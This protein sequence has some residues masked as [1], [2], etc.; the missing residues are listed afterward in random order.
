MRRKLHSEARHY[1]DPLT[2]RTVRQVTSHASVHHHPFFLAPAYDNRM[3]WL[4][5]VSHRSGRAEV[6]AEDRADG[7]LVQLTNQPELH[8]WSIHPSHD[9]TYLYY[10]AG[11]AAYRVEL[12]NH[13]VETVAEFEDAGLRARGMVA[14]GMGTT[15]LSRCDRYW[16]LKVARADSMDLVVIDTATRSARTVVQRDT[17]AHVQFCPDDS[18]LLFYAGSFKERMWT[19]RIDGSEHRSHYQRQEGEW[20]THESWIPGTMEL[21]F[22]DWPNRVRALHV[23]TGRIRDLVRTNA[24]HAAADRSGARMVADTNH[25]DHGLILFPTDGSGTVDALC[26]AGSSNEGEHWKGPFPYEHGPIKVQAAQH[27]HPH[28]T[29]SPDGEFVVFTS[30]RSGHAQVYEVPL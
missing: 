25:P 23:P 30:D 21:A 16:A 18:E 20:I 22:V 10:T 24:W 12:S 28:P 9:G 26:Q 6:W 7:A 2:G 14:A 11:S 5:F 1:S 15:A 29:F 3:R 19:V 17:V 27:S 8:E 4:F 13:E